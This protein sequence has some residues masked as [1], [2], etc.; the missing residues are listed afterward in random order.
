LL[1]DWSSRELTELQAYFAIERFES[2][3]IPLTD[4]AGNPKT[5]DALRQEEVA[6]DLEKRVQEGMPKPKR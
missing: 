4:T 1:S 2:A 5:L 3:E 6:K